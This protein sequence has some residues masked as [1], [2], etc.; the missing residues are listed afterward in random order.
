MEFDRYAQDYQA[1]VDAAAGVSVEGL[2]GEKARLIVEILAGKLGDPARL[3]VL[4][5]GCGIGLLDRE[6]AGGVAALCGVD[7]SLKSLQIAKSRAPAAHVVQYDGSRLPFAD[8]SFDAVLASCVLHHVP[9]PARAPF[10]AEMLRPLRPGGIA[11]VI[12]HNAFNPVT[13]FIVSRCAF[14]ADAVL[15]PCRETIDL[16]ERGGAAL[17]GRRYLGFLPFRHPLVERAERAFG[18]LPAGAQYCVWGRKGGRAPA[19]AA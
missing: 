14:D 19:A 9:P 16:L 8:A 18:W 5:L 3:R 10:I 11:L 15:L 1:A 6:L 17:A 4:D 13:R 12:E 7:V 2:A